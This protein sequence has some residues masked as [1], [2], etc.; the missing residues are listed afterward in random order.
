MKTIRMTALIAS[1][2]LAMGGAKAA[3][4]DLHNDTVLDTA[5]S[6]VWLKDWT[7][8]GYRPWATQKSWAEGLMVAGTS[9]WT[10]P[11]IDQYQGLWSSVGGYY[12]GLKSHFLTNDDEAKA[13]GPY[14]SS[15]EYE[16]NSND[17]YAFFTGYSGG[18]Y[19]H[20]KYLGNYG[21]AVRAA[22]PAEINAVP[23]PESFALVLVALVAAGAATRR[24]QAANAVSK[25]A[26]L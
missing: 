21:T 5:S 19:T 14:W 7:G 24:R 12:G 6:L 15:T 23:E 18:V 8:N 11:S 16:L 9:G 2:L 4:V 26:A 17:A 22:S 13:Y 1:G 25:R 10:L 20:P 3:L